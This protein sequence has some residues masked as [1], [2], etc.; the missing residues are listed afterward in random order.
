MEGRNYCGRIKFAQN[1]LRKVTDYAVGR[2][3]LLISVHPQMRF[4]I[5]LGPFTPPCRTEVLLLKD[6]T[7]P[8]N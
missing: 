7:H 1:D 8:V 4:T 6:T 3:G 2:Y 5:S